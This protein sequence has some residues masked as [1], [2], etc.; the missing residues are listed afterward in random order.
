MN[1]CHT[2]YFIG[3]S[4]APVR[5]P[6]WNRDPHFHKLGIKTQGADHSLEMSKPRFEPRFSEFQASTLSTTPRNLF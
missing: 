5:R 1:C 4:Q 2:P 3:S 6:G